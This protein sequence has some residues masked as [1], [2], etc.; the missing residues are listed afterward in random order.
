M[1]PKPTVYNPQREMFRV[2]LTSL[3]DLSHPLVKLGE[4]IN[5]ARFEE[6]LGRTFHAMLSHHKSLKVSCSGVSK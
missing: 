5:W 2:E 1:K 3:V 4:T 6:Q